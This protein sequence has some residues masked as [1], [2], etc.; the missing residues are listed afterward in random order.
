VGDE[1]RVR[2]DVRPTEVIFTRMWP[3]VA[4]G[5]GRVMATRGTPTS[6]WT[7]AF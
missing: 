6:F 5:M 7:M 3:G 4:V 2:G 1:G